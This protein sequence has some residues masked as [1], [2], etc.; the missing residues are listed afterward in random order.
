ME[1]GLVYDLDLVEAVLIWLDASIKSA[2]P[3]DIDDDSMTLNIAY[4]HTDC[5]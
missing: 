2:V 1:V 4:C 3:Y 5:Y